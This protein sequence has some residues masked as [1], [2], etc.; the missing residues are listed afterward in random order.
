[1]FHDTELYTDS[2]DAE[3][4]ARIGFLILHRIHVLK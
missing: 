4:H 1:M 2:Y 3:T